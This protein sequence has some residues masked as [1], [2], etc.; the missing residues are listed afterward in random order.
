V[1][2]LLVDDHPMFRDGLRSA[3][4]T[5]GEVDVVEEASTVADAVATC[6]RSEPDVVLMDL[7]LPDGSGIDATKTILERRP[8]TLVIVL[9]MTDDDD[10]V[11]AA[12]AAGARGYLL[13]G[14]D[15]AAILAAVAG[16][17]RG[18][19]ILGAG[20]AERV[21]AHFAQPASRP[22]PLPQLTERER[23]VLRL[24]AEGLTNPAIAERLYVSP[25]TVRNHVSNIL[26]KLQVGSRSDASR[27]AR[28]AGI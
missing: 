18:E 14:A 27:K 21:I 6:E 15:R 2:V 4:T 11:F 20:V 5:S 8:D 26:M 17:A 3:L 7:Q 24:V 19:A 9:T 13:K 12:L 22:T 16:V 28:E 23:E 10:A 1:K 25:K